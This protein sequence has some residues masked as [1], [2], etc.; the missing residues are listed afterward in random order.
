LSDSR[1]TRVDWPSVDGIRLRCVTW[2]SEGRRRGTVIVCT[3]RTEFVEK[4]Q[5]VVQE[6]L[7]RGLDVI[8]FDWRGQG[9]S[10]R[11]LQ[12]RA[13]GH[14]GRFED[15]LADLAA[16]VSLADQ[17]KLP[18]PRIMLAHS[19]GGQVGIRFLHDRP[20]VFAGAAM[21]APMFGIR[22]SGL[23]TH[24]ARLAVEAMVLAGQREE[25][26]FG[27]GPRAYALG[28]FEGNLLT[29]SVER[30][31]HLQSLLQA[32]PDLAL[33]GPTFG[34]LAAALRSIRTSGRLSFARAVT[35]PVLLAL[36]EQ[37]GIVDN[38]AIERMAGQ[39]PHAELVQMPAA[40]HE[41]L[42]EQDDIRAAFWAAFDRWLSPVLNEG[43]PPSS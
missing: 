13:K 25:F 12:D 19:M 37:E 2:R 31:R 28:P 9:L 32:D 42:I 4:Y 1:E 35:T 17:Q 21:T 6:L 33:G 7:D 40:R 24:A 27:Q 29:G 41:I 20:D 11:L 5:E 36:G 34:W 18:R 16:V 22:L 3:G 39:L 15:Y 14:V 26:A 38:A 30:Y 43:L 8:A 23:P 10:D